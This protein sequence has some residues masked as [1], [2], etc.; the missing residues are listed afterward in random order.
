MQ[1]F[2]KTYK[3][4]S[5]LSI[6]VSSQDFGRILHT[7]ETPFRTQ[8]YFFL[9]V[10][11]GVSQH[12]IDLTDFEVR[13]NE[14]LFVLPHQI[15]QPPFSHGAQ[16]YYKIGFDAHCLS[17]LPKQYPFLINP[18]NNPK[19]SLDP[20]AVIRMRS[21]FLLLIDLL[22]S[23][24]ADQ[25]LILAHLNSLLTEINAAYFVNEKAPSHDKLSKFLQF[26]MIVE[27]QL[28]EHPSMDAIASQLAINTNSLYSIVKQYAGVS[29]KE[30]ITNRVILEAQ[31]RLY[32]SE[33]SIKELAY[34]L[35]FNDPEYFSRLFKKVSGKTI[36]EFLVLS[37]K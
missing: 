13:D 37:G 28:C 30:F 34:T 3:Q 8:D 36:A 33:T 11:K 24:D 15:H 5:K 17:M 9:L 26:K 22:Q 29:P 20:A 31:R 16:E 6:R 23:M 19:I 2:L 12:H 4:H 1:D 35:G 7:F 21:V 14:L 27:E 18:Y 32:Y 10:L 25:E